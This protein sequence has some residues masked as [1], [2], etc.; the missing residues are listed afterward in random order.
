MDVDVRLHAHST[1]II[2]DKQAADFQRNLG[3]GEQHLL[4]AAVCFELDNITATCASRLAGA[5][6]GRRRVPKVAVLHQELKACRA[7]LHFD[8]NLLWCHPGFVLPERSVIIQAS[9][10]HASHGVVSMIRQQIVF[11]DLHEVASIGRNI[12]ALAQTSRKASTIRQSSSPRRGQVHGA[13]IG[14]VRVVVGICI[15]IK[16][17]IAEQLCFIGPAGKQG[18]PISELPGIHQPLVSQLPA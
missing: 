12:R 1:C 4:P 13:R 5:P 2:V 18:I 9:C 11:S 8:V 17:L 10:R 6:V 7:G 3:K 14:E 15:L 16:E